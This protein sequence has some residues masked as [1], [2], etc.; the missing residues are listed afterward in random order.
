MGET[1]PLFSTAF[2]SSVQIESRPD[3]LTGEAGALVQ[4][5]LMEKTGIIDWLTEQLHDP[6]NQDLITYPLADLS[7]TQLLLLGHGWRDQD[8]ADRL[9]QDPGL[10]VASSS[11]RGNTPLDK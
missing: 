5:E 6:R 10:W 2:N 7:R 3:H 8:D 1:L 4:R 11:H 9:R